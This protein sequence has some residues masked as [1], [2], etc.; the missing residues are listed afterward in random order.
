MERNSGSV[1]WCFEKFLGVD[2]AEAAVSACNLNSH[3]CSQWQQ[4]QTLLQN[5]QPCPMNGGSDDFDWILNID[6]CFSVAGVTGGQAE[7]KVNLWSPQ[8]INMLKVLWN[9]EISPKIK[10]FVWRKLNDKILTKDQLILRGVLKISSNP[11]LRVLQHL[12][13]VVVTLVFLL[14]YFERNLGLDSILG[15]YRY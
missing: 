7:F 9:V 13:G 15:E 8:T 2:T 4:L 11:L 14:S 5:A 6:G 1:G 12:H 10:I 3:L